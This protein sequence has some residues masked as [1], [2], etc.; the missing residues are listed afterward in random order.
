MQIVSLLQDR[1][2]YNKSVDMFGELLH[3][4]IMNHAIR[5]HLNI[6]EDYSSLALNYEKENNDYGITLYTSSWRYGGDNA[7][8]NI[9]AL[10]CEDLEFDCEAKEINDVLDEWLDIIIHECKIQELEKF[11]KEQ[12]DLLKKEQAERELFIKLRAKY[13]PRQEGDFFG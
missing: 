2:E 12:E 10:L 8:L 1:E 6:L 9:P 5:K 4:C 7:S 3:K 13:E 11:K